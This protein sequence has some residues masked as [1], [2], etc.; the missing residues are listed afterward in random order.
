[1]FYIGRNDIIMFHMKRVKYHLMNIMRT[2]WVER[3][4]AITG[5][6]SAARDQMAI[7]SGKHRKFKLVYDKTD[8]K[9]NNNVVF[10]SFVI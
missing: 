5:W 1:M 2:Y 3:N 8:W 4:V 10:W 9:I 6:K 7:Q